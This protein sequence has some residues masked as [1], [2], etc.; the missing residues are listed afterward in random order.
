M[1]LTVDIGNTNTVLGIFNNKT[2]IKSQQLAYPIKEKSLF[3]DILFE[4]LSQ[5]ETRI[6]DLFCAFRISTVTTRTADELA[7]IFSNL[8]QLVNTVDE[9]DAV[10]VS[11]SVPQALAEM[12]LMLRR[13]FRVDILVA[14]YTVADGIEIFYNTP[15]D[16]GP[17]R[18][19]D[20][21]AAKDL[22]GS[23]CIIV[24][25]GTATT[26]DVISPAGD[27]LGG[28][29]TPGLVISQD[30]LASKAA[31]LRHVRL[32]P[33]DFVVGRSTTESIRSGLTFGHASM[34]EGMCSRIEKE[35]GTQADLILT[36]GLAKTMLEILDRRFAYE[37][38]LTLHG[39]KI[40]YD[41]RYG[42]K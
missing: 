20:V 15:Q 33:P 28:A 2:A 42:R 23:P 9:I 21:V 29:I 39:L 25:L 8:L 36:G 11:S 5:H 40:A 4:D 12:L 1:L 22:Y 32:F 38:W 14:D 7:I 41:K 34:I 10:A 26:F 3:Y 19:V 17:D 35:L 27:Y 30:A 24:D 31:A 13:F 16:V 18:I 37:P 6:K